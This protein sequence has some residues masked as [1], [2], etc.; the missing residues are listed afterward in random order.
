MRMAVQRGRSAA[1][2][3]DA[4]P[5]AWGGL[6]LV[7]RERDVREL[8]RVLA[9]ARDGRGGALSLEGV[10]G[11][12]K[13]RLVELARRSAEQAGMTVLLAK[14]SELEA[15]VPFGLV[16]QL[17]APCLHRA[18]DE[19]RARLL[20]GMARPAVALFGGV[21]EG[22]APALSEPPLALLHGLH[23]LLE[24]LA[25]PAA[26]VSRYRCWS[27]PTMRSGPTARRC[28]SSCTC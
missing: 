1:P 9:G 17:F 21:A 25:L 11:A 13:S 4:D 22:H 24:N 10:P 26:R 20:S 14:G 5:A 2:E 28:A 6:P 3:G 15:D 8:Q 19:E 12:G 16:M 7:G 18:A 27:P 23:W